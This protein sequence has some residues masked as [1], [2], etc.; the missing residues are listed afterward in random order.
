MTRRAEYILLGTGTVVALLVAAAVLAVIE[1]RLFGR[2]KDLTIVAL[3][4]KVPPFYAN[5]FRQEDARSTEFLLS[6]PVT[7]VRGRPLLPVIDQ[8]GPH[9]LLGFRNRDIPGSAAVIVVGDSQT[10][11]NNVALSQNWPEVLQRTVPLRVYSMATGG[12]GPLQYL[13]MV[14]A[15]LRF[16]P[17]LVLIALYLG[18]DLHEAFRTAYGTEYWKPFR[19]N[20]ELTVGSIKAPRF[21]P[22]ES[23]LLTVSLPSG[24]TVLTPGLRLLAVDLAEPAVAAGLAITQQALRQTH[25]I[26][27]ANGVKGIVVLI[28]SKERVVA[29]ALGDNAP[30]DE[31]LHSL[32]RYEKEI[33]NRLER[34]VAEL[35]ALQ[36]IDTAGALAEALRKGTA[37]YPPDSNGHPIAAGYE[38]IASAV[39]PAVRELL[40]T[41]EPGF[42]KVTL[43]GSAEPWYFHL[44][45]D[46]AYRLH[47]SAIDC[48]RSEA[49]EAKHDILNQ[50]PFLGESAAC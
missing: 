13:D 23:D 21:P 20:P 30:K 5:V 46:G 9:D 4:K 2:P 22:V 39:A 6:D 24:P 33:T 26:L 12:W 19:V 14:R 29:D 50:Y 32:Q 43:E 45:R 1:P 18:N 31:A 3:D 28:P 17:Q 48:H 16:R 44:T 8:V 40:T 49:R 34:E 15:A 42:Y 35:P 10:Y 41:L 11:G 36:L 7:V 47:G 27:D 38:I 25:G 37:L